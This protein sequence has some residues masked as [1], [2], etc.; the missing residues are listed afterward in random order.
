MADPGVTDYYERY[1]NEGQPPH[2]LGDQLRSVFERNIGA[3]YRCLDV[4]CGDGRK[5]GPWLAGH[6]GGYVG[7]DVSETAVAEARALGLDARTIEDAAALPF[8]DAEFDAVVC[9]EVLEHLFEPQHAL[10]EIR[11]VLR[12]GGT[13]IATVPNVAYWRRRLELAFLGRWDPHGDDRSVN[14]PWR[15]PHLRF[16][17]PRSLERLVVVAGL[18][19]V[20]IG[21]FNGAFLYDLPTMGRRLQVRR[22]S[23][24]YRRLERLRPSLL[25][26]GLYAVAVKPD[27]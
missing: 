18:R 21:G 5:S 17:N 25:G 10:A 7:V 27:A 14:E 24:V 8:P 11:R 22:A 3:G 23:R 9:I 6:A 2:E 26:I 20:E 12:P 15:D 13:A 16:F 19:P 1:W 4:G